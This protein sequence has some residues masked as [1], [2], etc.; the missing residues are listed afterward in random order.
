MRRAAGLPGPVDRVWFTDRPGG[1][2]GNFGH[3]QGPIRIIGRL[4]L[5]CNDLG[6]L[7]MA[8]LLCSELIDVIFPVYAACCY[9]P[10]VGTRSPKII[11]IN[12]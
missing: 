10:L 11:C 5:E 4:V 8:D 7:F 9:A 12:C 1:R 6:L 3:T 2:Q